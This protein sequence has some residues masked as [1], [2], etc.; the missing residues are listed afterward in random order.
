MGVLIDTGVFI[1]WERGR[2]S[3]DFS[4]W[5][6]YGEAQ[7]SV[8][9]ASELLVGVWRA[10]TEERKS[11]RQAFVE[12]ILKR[13]RIVEINLGVARVHAELLADL[14]AKGTMIGPHDLWIGA[15]AKYAGDAVLTLDTVEFAR[16]PGL[17]VLDAS[18]NA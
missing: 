8:V 6:T 10:N 3:Y 17:T 11:R 13:L 18:S 15:T 5:A 12:G 1:Q 4:Q 14:A 9:T 16:I 2:R 7:I